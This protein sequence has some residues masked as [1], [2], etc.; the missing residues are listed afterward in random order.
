MRII[1]VL[2]LWAAYSFFAHA[3]DVLEPAIELTNFS[4]Q[5][6][7]V[8]RK[9]HK[10]IKEL[11]TQVLQN[12]KQKND[13]FD[14]SI[15]SIDFPFLIDFDT[16][17]G[18]GDESEI[19]LA[20]DIKDN[21]KCIARILL[22]RALPIRDP[23]KKVDSERKILEY[24]KIYRGSYIEN[25]R[26]ILVMD[27]IPGINLTHPSMKKRPLILKAIIAKEILVAAQNFYKQG[28][29]HR[30]IKLSNMHVDVVDNWPVVHFVDFGHSCRKEEAD[31]VFCGTPYMQAP[32][33]FTKSRPKYD[34]GQEMQAVGKAMAFFLTAND[35]EAHYLQI[36]TLDW[37]R[38]NIGFEG[39]EKCSHLEFLRACDDL[40]IK[41]YF[42]VYKQHQIVLYKLFKELHDTILELTEPKAAERPSPERVDAIIK[43]L[44]ELESPLKL[45]PIRKVLD[46]G[47]VTPQFL[48]KSPKESPKTP[49]TPPAERK[50]QSLGRSPDSRKSSPKIRPSE[51]VSG[52]TSPPA[53]P[54]AERQRQSLGTEA[55]SSPRIRTSLKG[56]PK[57]SSS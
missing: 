32:E 29:F 8:H 12:T 6:A 35:V 24:L 57:T 23:L 15:L 44:N 53:T 34:Y 7:N 17:L 21:S 19:Y 47:S 2:V 30:D 1:Q 5:M 13:Q 22:E 4:P 43:K 42:E 52:L 40:F 28:A 9:L 49:T 26:P 50:T 55:K 41:R 33:A 3:M 25:S 48:T 27:Y 37:C 10:G 38:H 16:M 46:L 56:S 51:S 14:G 39:C 11:Q 18:G 54:P 36:A 31:R 45:E 20:Q